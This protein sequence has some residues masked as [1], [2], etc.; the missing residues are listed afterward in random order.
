MGQRGSELFPG[1]PAGFIANL[2]RQGFR[3]TEGLRMW[4]EAGGSIR[5]QTW[6]RLFGEIRAS[7]GRLEEFMSLPPDIPPSDDHFVPW[8][9]GRPGL[10]AYQVDVW[11]RERETGAVMATPFTLVS[12]EV[13]SPSEAIDQ[14]IDLYSD[15]AEKYNQ[16]ILGASLTGLFILQGRPR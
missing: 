3:P 15:H 12:D 2:V 9:A 4:R 10:R 16:Q 1:S 7:I 5:T 11:V 6:F 13:L 8:S 14:A